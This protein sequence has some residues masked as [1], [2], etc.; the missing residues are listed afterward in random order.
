MKPLRKCLYPP[1][2]VGKIVIQLYQLLEELIHKRAVCMQLR[3]T[4]CVNSEVNSNDDIY[5][6]TGKARPRSL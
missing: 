1:F 2:E 4:K 3:R 5:I 6:K